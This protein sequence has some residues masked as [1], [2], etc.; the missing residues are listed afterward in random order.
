M[1]PPFLGPAA[2]DRGVMDIHAHHRPRRHRGRQG[3]VIR[4]AQIITKPHDGG[5]IIRHDN[6]VPENTGCLCGVQMA[7]RQ[8]TARRHRPVSALVMSSAWRGGRGWRRGRARGLGRVIILEHGPASGR[9]LIE[10]AFQAFRHQFFVRNVEKAEPEYIALACAGL[11]AAFGRMGGW[12]G[13]G[14]PRGNTGE[15]KKPMHGGTP[16]IGQAS[17]YVSPLLFG[18]AWSCLH[19]SALQFATAVNLFCHN[20]SMRRALRK[21][22]EKYRTV[23]INP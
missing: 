4:Q 22:P 3:R 1:Q 15:R 14:N 8:I 12:R 18:I 5:S 11:I 10:L 19:H 16:G 13:A 9:E 7:G 2:L 20:R 21:F 6:P 17:H 23:F